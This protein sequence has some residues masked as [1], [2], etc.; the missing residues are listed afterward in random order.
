MLDFGKICG[1]SG[2]LAVFWQFFY[3]FIGLRSSFH[4]DLSRK[5]VDLWLKNMF[6]GRFGVLLNLV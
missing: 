2:D 3:R 1:Y 4:Q 6:S 5:N